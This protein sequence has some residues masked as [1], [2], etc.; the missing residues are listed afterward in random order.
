M[1]I[2]KS[3]LIWGELEVGRDFGFAESMVVT[4]ETSAAAD[5]K[6]A[7][8]LDPRS[9]S[10]LGRGTRSGGGCILQSP[11]NI[12]KLLKLLT[13]RCFGVVV[14]NAGREEQSEGVENIFCRGRE[15]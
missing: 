15:S 3:T 8:A 14:A 9:I 6:M 2:S 11:E 4:I 12:L 7:V 13:G 1:T 5:K 10:T